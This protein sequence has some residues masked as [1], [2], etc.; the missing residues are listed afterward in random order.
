LGTK[1]QKFGWL[2]ETGYYITTGFSKQHE[3]E[4]MFW[5]AKMPEKAVQEK[6]ID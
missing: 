5:D 2:G 1:P 4:Y 6:A 3:R